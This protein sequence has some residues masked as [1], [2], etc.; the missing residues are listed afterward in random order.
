MGDLFHELVPTEFIARTWRVIAPASPQQD[1]AAQRHQ[2]RGQ[3][4]AVPVFG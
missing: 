2:A 4:Q 1:Q 3:H